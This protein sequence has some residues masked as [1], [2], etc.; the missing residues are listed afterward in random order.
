VIASFGVAP[1][2]KEC[3]VVECAVAGD[4]CPPPPSDCGG[5][6]ATCS[7]DAGTPSD[8][9]CQQ[10]NASCLCSAGR[11]SCEANKCISHCFDDTECASSTSGAIKC[12][13]GTCVQCTSDRDCSNDAF[14]NNGRC[15]APC[16]SDGDCAGF[17]RCLNGRCIDSGCQTDRECISATGNVE[18]L[19]GTDGACITPCETDLE[20]GNPKAY[21][22]FSCV[23]R[24]CVATGCQSDKDCRLLLTGTA[25]DTTLPLNEHVVCR[26]KPA[27]N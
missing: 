10:Y 15:L 11:R 21:K 5:L 7:A 27:Q 26:E 20:C 22:F 8:I 9:A 2:G 3:A 13:G 14:C 16:A 19:C 18:A 24:Q 4:C 6:L 17:K 23:N 1:T 25:D 12:S